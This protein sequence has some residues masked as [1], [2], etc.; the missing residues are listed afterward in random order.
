MWFVLVCGGALERG[1][2]PAA[3]LIGPCPRELDAAVAVFM[4]ACNEFRDRVALAEEHLP[5]A[6]SADGRQ[7]SAAILAGQARALCPKHREPVVDLERCHASTNHH[8]RASG[9]AGRRLR[10]ELA[11]LRG[12][13]EAAVVAIVVVDPAGEIVLVNAAAQALFGYRRELVGA[14]G[15]V[16]LLLP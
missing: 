11:L 12:L 4:Y 16:E 3:G 1:G 14:R 15:D 2:M 6:A 5:T 9:P 8:S 10:R 7:L 13:F